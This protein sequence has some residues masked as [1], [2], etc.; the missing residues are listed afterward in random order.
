MFSNDFFALTSQ[1]C[2]MQGM[3]PLSIHNQCPHY[4][5]N[6]NLIRVNIVHVVAA[7]RECL[8]NPIDSLKAE[9]SFVAFTICV[10]F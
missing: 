10:Y 2:F 7:D 3:L 1:D 6:S 8:M 5:Y 9:N 4:L